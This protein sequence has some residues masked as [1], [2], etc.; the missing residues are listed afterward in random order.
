MKLEEFD[1]TQDPF[2]I[3][4]DGPVHNWAGHEDLRLDL[5]DLIKGI[6][7]R[8]I[9]I[10]E[11]VV[12]HGEYGAG[13]SHALRYLKT[14]IVE[15]KAEYNS[16]ALYLER[17]RVANKL[18]FLE[19]YKYI[20]K[21]IGREQIKSYCGQMKAHLD[22]IT[23]DLATKAG[24][25]DLKN[26]SSF[27]D[28]AVSNLP[29]DD[30]PMIKML[31]NGA[32]EGSNIFEVLSGVDKSDEDGYEGKID[33]DFIA[34]KVLSDFFRV[35][36]SELRPNI[37]ILESIYLFIDECEVLAEAKASESELVFTGLR[38]LINGLPYRFGLIMSFSAATALIEAIMP[39]H[40]LRRMT[41]PYIEVPMLADG[42]AVSFLR[43]QLNFFRTE[44]S[45]YNG[46]FY[47]FS[48]EAIAFI[49]E[50]T[51]TLTPRNLFIDCKR[52]LERAIRRFDLA[53]GQ[54]ISRETAE[55]VLRGY[56]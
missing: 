14:Q 39:Q 30:R 55:S 56:R 42:D 1:L 54:T 6:R 29:L 47:P 9:G 13:K 50:N 34:A 35:L 49:I 51:T 37:R 23:I 4:P 26:K 40:L 11:F 7:A 22:E 31:V 19:L 12:L 52:V 25:A 45:E 53:P 5:I 18:N 33:S 36:T 32:E 38:E 16:L 20:I 44:N 27:F 46:Q 2:P 24:M 17:P 43:T 41:R 8:D 15:D 3:V 48:N 28:Q 10:S 21:I